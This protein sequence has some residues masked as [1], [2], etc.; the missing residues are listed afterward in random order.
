MTNVTAQQ[1]EEHPITTR[2]IA[3]A[4][5]QKKRIAKR[6]ADKHLYPPEK[7]PVSVFMAGSPGAG[8]TEASKEL[9][10]VLSENG[11]DILRIDPDELRDEFE[12]Y[13]GG[14][15]RLFQPAVS[16]LVEKLLDVALK[17]HQSFLLD[18]TFTNLVKAR[19]NVARSLG[20]SRLVQILYV[21]QD[22]LLAWE[23]VEAREAL[24]GRRIPVESFLE[25][26]FAARDVANRI[27]QEFGELVMVDLLI[28]NHDGSHR[29]Y[30][31][32]VEQIDTH[33]AEAYSR[34]SLLQKLAERTRKRT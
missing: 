26:Y 13:H 33:I 24:E 4:R 19:E 20:K 30:V 27:K 2:A 14:N 22:P 34:K 25:Q 31:Q 10:A 7:Y 17:Q 6:I 1:A 12:D 5:K 8:K 3:F 18:G 9:I 23:F 15:A 29:E 21:Y 11:Q 16:I 32:N 28:K